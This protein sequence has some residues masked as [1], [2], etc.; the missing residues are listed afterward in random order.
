MHKAPPNR[1]TAAGPFKI[2]ICQWHYTPPR[3]LPQF[4]SSGQGGESL[5]AATP[6]AAVD[7]DHP[8]E[9]TSP[10]PPHRNQSTARNFPKPS[11]TP[12]SSH[13]QS[14]RTPKPLRLPLLLPPLLR[15]VTSAPRFH[16]VQIAPTQPQHPRFPRHRS[17]SSRRGAIA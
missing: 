14:L 10:R 5:Q 11:T 12:P 13:R 15:R 3:R 17:P 16:P 6:Y 2:S 7:D 9:T 8:S 1:R 4:P